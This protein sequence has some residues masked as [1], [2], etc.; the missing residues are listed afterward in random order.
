M[1]I[2]TTQDN[3]V[4]PIEKILGVIKKNIRAIHALAK[5]KKYNVMEFLEIN[6]IVRED[7]FGE[8]HLEYR[9]NGQLPDQVLT[10]LINNKK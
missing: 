3:K 6:L 7:E 10:D 9:L 5:N 1:I 2:K 4:V 8:I